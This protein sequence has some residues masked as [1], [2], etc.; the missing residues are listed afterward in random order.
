M[1]YRHTAVL[2]SFLIC[3]F[4][5]QNEL[6][7]NFYFNLFSPDKQSQ[8]NFQ[9]TREGTALYS[10]FVDKKTIIK[11][12]RLGIRTK[13]G[14]SFESDFEL[15]RIDTLTQDETWKP[16]WG[17]ESE[18]R[19]HAI[20]MKVQLRQKKDH[21]DFVIEFRLYDNG[22]GFRY[23]FPAQQGLYNF[24][25]ADELTSFP[26][27]GNHQAFWI[28]GDYDSNEY[29]YSRSKLSDIH[30]LK[31][32]KENGISFKSLI[33]DS[34]VQ[35]PLTMK[36]E[37]GYY[38]SIHEAALVN[39]PAMNLDVQ[40]T[41]NLLQAHLVPDTY[42]NKA[43]LHA[44]NRTPWRVVLVGRKAAELL[45]NRIILNLNEPNSLTNIDFIK[46][47]KFLGI[48]WEMHIGKSSWDYSGRWGWE[49]PYKDLKPNGRHGANTRNVKNYIDFASAHGIPYLLVESW[50]TGWED[51][52]G[53]WKERIFSF[54][55]AYPDFDVNEISNYAKTKNV[56]LLMHHETSSAVTDYERQM[57]SAYQFMQHYGY[58]G[59]KTGYVGKIIPRGEHHDGQWMVNHYVRVAQKTGQYGFM[60]DAHQ[61]VRPTGLHRTYPNWMACEAARGNEFN[62]WSIGNPPEHECILP[63]TRLLGGPMDYT[64][65]IFQIKMNVYDSAKTEQVHTTLCKQL[66]LYVTMYSPL[67]MAADLIENYEKHLDAFQFI[68]DVP[69]DWDRS[70]VLDA[71]PGDFI[72][73]ARKDK[74]SKD[75]YLGAITNEQGREFVP[76]LSFLEEGTKYE[77]QIYMDGMNADWRQNPM[78]YKIEKRTVKRNNK[79]KIKLAPGGGCAI[80]FKAL[81]D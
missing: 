1:I 36:T 3:I 34:T 16:I 77:A 71:E 28:P 13:E 30:A 7:A 46:P 48:W 27:N 12:G 25:I 5:H 63:F 57:D 42:G 53:S 2:I 64:P 78:D 52:Y 14:P 26:L 45:S 33:S 9:L 41:L 51:W 44:G 80:R 37:D 19:D 60:L 58:G 29:V 40:R 54:T 22:M 18:I 56:K 76:E 68:K 6:H 67:Q 20:S 72:Y 50:N 74:K 31:E 43:Y 15:I 17:E 73:M 47:G 69:T 81:N 62:A 21:L 38:L 55:T 65:G 23:S 10:Y 59:V 70:I 11:Q 39:Y 49:I 35:T 4:L 8:L 79:L 61:P 24:I 66:A 32:K 75:W